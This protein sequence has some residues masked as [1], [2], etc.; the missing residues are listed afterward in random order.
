[1]ISCDAGRMTDGSKQLQATLRHLTAILKPGFTSP[2]LNDVKMDQNNS[3]CL[4]ICIAENS[5][6]LKI[7]IAENESKLDW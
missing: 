5:L 4:K 7:C 3:K 1:M 2:L 6:G